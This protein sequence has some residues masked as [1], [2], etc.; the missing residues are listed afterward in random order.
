MNLKELIEQGLDGFDEAV[1]R[2]HAQSCNMIGYPRY[3]EHRFYRMSPERMAFCEDLAKRR[4][5][6]RYARSQRY[7][8][9]YTD[10]D[11]HL[12]G[13]WGEVATADYLGLEVN[14]EIYDGGD[15]HMPGD[16]QLP[17]GEW[18]ECK[19]RGSRSSFAVHPKHGAEIKADY[20]VLVWP[21]T[22]RAE[23]VLVGYFNQEIW[24]QN[25]ER[26]NWSIGDQWAIHPAWMR[27]IN[28]LKERNG[29]KGREE[30][31]DVE[32]VGRADG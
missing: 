13:I 6:K 18:I 1:Y 15:G 28:E 26:V 27:D 19:F 4:N 14:T 30:N 3:P 11:T 16:L 21:S 2:P 25:R 17:N 5:T 8:A 22:G 31:P 10:E 29:A 24:A 23:F 7:T 32:S 20:G 12:F 9:H